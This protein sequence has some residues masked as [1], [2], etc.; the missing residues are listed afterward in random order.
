MGTAARPTLDDLLG[1]LREVAREQK[2]LERAA[3]RQALG[4]HQL[5]DQLYEELDRRGIQ[6]KA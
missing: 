6:I 5:L 2:R 4:I 1:R 3:R